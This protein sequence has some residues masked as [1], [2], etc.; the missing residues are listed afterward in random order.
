MDKP[1]T[2]ESLVFTWIEDNHTDDLSF[3][4]QYESLVTVNFK[5]LGDKTVIEVT[6]SQLSSASLMK[7]FEEG[8]TCCLR[9]I[10]EELTKNLKQRENI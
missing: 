9:S 8:W 2:D 5:E 4:R 6:H 3:H 10:E 1:S 7:D